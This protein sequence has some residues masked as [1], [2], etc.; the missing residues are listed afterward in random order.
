MEVMLGEADRAI[1]EIVGEPQ[2]DRDF[3]QPPLVKLGPRAGEPR[4]ELAPPDEGRKIERGA[5][6]F[7]IVLAPRL[8]TPD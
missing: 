5:F 3:A 8:L 6:S 7:A 2:L 4:L 1:F